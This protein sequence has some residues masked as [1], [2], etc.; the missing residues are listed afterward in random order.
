MQSLQKRANKY[1]L[2]LTFETE[3]N[4]SIWFEMKKHYSHSTIAR[5]RSYCLLHLDTT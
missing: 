5:A 3:D 1:L 2:Q 4:Y